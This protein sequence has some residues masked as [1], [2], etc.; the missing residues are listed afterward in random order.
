M[1]ESEVYMD[2]HSIV[3]TTLNVLAY[4]LPAVFIWNLTDVIVSAIVGAA[5]G[6][7]RNGI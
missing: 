1:L 3:N 4:V 2:L 6:R 5:T 7:K